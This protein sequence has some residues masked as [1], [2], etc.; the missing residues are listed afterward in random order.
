MRP[1]PDEAAAV[2]CPVCGRECDKL[3]ISD[4]DGAAI[5][6]DMC[7]TEKYAWEYEEV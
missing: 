3:Y 5:G 4:A 1:E 2:R 7:V 6:C